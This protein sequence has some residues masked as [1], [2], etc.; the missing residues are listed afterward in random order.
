LIVL[1]RRRRVRHNVATFEEYCNERWG[2]SIRRVEQLIAASAFGEKAN[3]CS[4]KVPSNESHIRPLLERLKEDD[5]R[6]AVWRDV[7]S[8]M[9]GAKIK[10]ANVDHAITRFLGLRNKEYVTLTE[11]HEMSP[12][13]RAAVLGTCHS[14]EGTFSN[15]SVT[16]SAKAAAFDQ[17]IDMQRG[18]VGLA[19]GRLGVRPAVRPASA[20]AYAVPETGGSGIP[21]PGRL[22]NGS[23]L[24]SAC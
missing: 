21:L 10:S 6:I 4:L 1:S 14:L 9:N 8:T 11:W 7:L 24:R 19:L 16:L 18:C 12:A 13:D 20:A 15:R 5:D 22:C 2:K 17:P 23:W 3:N